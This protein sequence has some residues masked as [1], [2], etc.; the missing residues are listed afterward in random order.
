[1]KKRGC[2][3]YAF[4]VLLA[5]VAALMAAGALDQRA[6]SIPNQDIGFFESGKTDISTAETD[7]NFSEPDVF[8]DKITELAS[9]SY[10]GQLNSEEKKIYSVL[11]EGVGNGEKRFK[12]EDVNCGKYEKYCERAIEA[13]TYD[14][15]EFFWLTTGYRLTSRHAAGSAIGNVELEAKYYAYW[16]YCLE[17]DRRI[18]ELDA[19]VDAVVLRARDYDS[20]YERIVFVHDYLIEH[21]IYDHDSLNAYYKTKHD[22]ACEY[23]FSAYGCLVNGKTVCAGYAKAFQLIMNELGYECMYVVGDANGAHAWNCILIENEG[24]Y[25]DVTWDDPDYIY[26]EPRYEYFCIT[27]ENLS[28]THE[29]DAVFV[30]PDCRAEKYNYF[31]YNGFR[32]NEYD[33]ET[34]C[35][36]VEM[37]KDRHVISI[38]FASSAELSEAYQDLFSSGRIYEIPALTEQKSISY[39]RNEDHFTLTIFRK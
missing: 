17:K 14:Y 23:I 9:W 8:P 20:D 7:T 3:S 1:M 11:L 27:E 5:S 16:E 31:V 36:I 2:I 29:P 12:F 19:A 38:Q 37:Q 35:G 22:P 18:Q 32:M 24:Y 34:L 4:V 13:L 15:P 28:K 21:A 25:I 33:F 26:D 30:M 39:S 10:Y 6:L